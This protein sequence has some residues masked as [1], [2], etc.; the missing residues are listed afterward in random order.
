MKIQMRAPL[1]G[2]ALALADVPDEVFAQA[3]AGDGVAIDPTSNL[4]C[5]PFD[6]VV[7]PVGDARHAVTVRAANGVEALVH[8]GIDTVALAGAGFELLAKPGDRI[9]AGAPLLRFDMDA[10]ARKA[11]SLVTPVVLS[12]KGTVTR[13]TTGRKVAQGDVLFEV[14]SGEDA[15][16]A[17]DSVGV[18]V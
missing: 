18:D 5:A 13:R 3:M 17:R 12:A 6:G 4:V 11:K 10:V 7:V 1:D 15:P 9:A 16:V 14:E 8:V 2:W